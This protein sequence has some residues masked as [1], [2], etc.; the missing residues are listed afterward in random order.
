MLEGRRRWPA[1]NSTLARRSV[2]NSSDTPLSLR[3]K[4]AEFKKMA[5]TARDADI[6]EELEL[7]AL[8]YLERAKELEGRL[9]GAA[10]QEGSGAGMNP[11]NSNRA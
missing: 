3:A 8:R 4:A 7:L 9:S 1:E 10:G 2:G 6:V 11:E 5:M